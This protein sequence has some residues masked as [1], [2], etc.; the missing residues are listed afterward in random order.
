MR[1]PNLVIWV[2]KLVVKAQSVVIIVA[3]AVPV[4]VLHV[5]ITLSLAGHSS[6]D[7]LDWILA[8]L[9]H[10]VCGVVLVRETA[11]QVE[12]GNLIRFISYVFTASFPAI[13]ELTR[14]AV[15]LLVR[16]LHFKLLFAKDDGLHA[17]FV[18]TVSFAQ[19]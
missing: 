11:L 6:L 12:S 16:V 13:H 18:Q 2:L 1:E 7:G 17:L 9:I 4:L 19:I 8:L 10:C 3:F 14:T 5:A 15:K